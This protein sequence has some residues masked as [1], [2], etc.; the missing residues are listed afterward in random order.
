MEILTLQFNTS[1]FSSSQNSTQFSGPS[2]LL[3]NGIC[4]KKEIILS[5]LPKKKTNIS[6]SHNSLGKAHS[7]DKCN[8]CLK[9]DAI[10][11]IMVIWAN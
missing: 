4:H 5:P 11:Q 6:L 8:V 10:L 3:Y 2:I 1:H 9:Y 7:M